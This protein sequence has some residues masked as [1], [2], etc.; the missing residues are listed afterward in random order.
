LPGSRRLRKGTEWGTLFGITLKP[1]IFRPLGMDV[2]QARPLGAF[3][4]I[5]VVR[6]KKDAAPREAQAEMSALSGQ[7]VRP[8]KVEVDA[9]LAPMHAQVTG[10]A[11]QALLLLLGAVGAV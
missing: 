11:R 1:E 6:L 9:A 10:G 2:S 8:F 5:S 3:D 4:Y 7:L